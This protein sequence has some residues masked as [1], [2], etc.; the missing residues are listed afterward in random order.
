MFFRNLCLRV[1]LCSFFVTSVSNE[2]SCDLYSSSLSTTVS[3]ASDNNE[4]TVTSFAGEVK[5]PLRTFLL[6]FV[7]VTVTNI[8]SKSRNKVT[9]TCRSNDAHLRS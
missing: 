7:P 9:V 8:S 4:I 6:C 5:R 1:V 2:R 3:P